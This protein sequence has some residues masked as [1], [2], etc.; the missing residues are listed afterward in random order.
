MVHF[1]QGSFLKAQD[2]LILILLACIFVKCSHHIKIYTRQSKTK[3]FSAANTTFLF[4]AISSILADVLY[5]LGVFHINRGLQTWLKVSFSIAYLF[6]LLNVS[7]F[8]IELT[9]NK[10]ILR[11]TKNTKRAWI[12]II[13]FIACWSF[14]IFRAIMFEKTTSVQ[15]VGS[16]GCLTVAVTFLFGGYRL[17]ASNYA[18]ITTSKF[19]KT[20]RKS[21]S[22]IQSLSSLFENQRRGKKR[23]FLIS[24]LMACSS[25]IQAAILLY[26]NY[27]QAQHTRISR[28]ENKLYSNFVHMVSFGNLLLILQ[29]ISRKKRRKRSKTKAQ[30]IKERKVKHLIKIKSPSPKRK[31]PMLKLVSASKKQQSKNNNGSSET[32]SEKFRTANYFSDMREQKEEIEE[33]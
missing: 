3:R 30:S 7:C 9:L 4:I 16:V 26:W 22:S 31:N 24:I 8:W 23:F 15:L 29:V 33:K 32:V 2:I 28:E 17:W 5:V 6:G 11:R 12:F 25:L 1:N 20:Q 18:Q 10:S 14:F 21:S 19:K 27:R 13:M